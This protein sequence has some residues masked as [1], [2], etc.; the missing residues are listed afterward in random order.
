M[1][2]LSVIN[3]RA[4][5]CF[6]FVILSLGLFSCHRATLQNTLDEI[7]YRLPAPVE[8][9]VMAN[10]I[11]IVDNY[12]VFHHS[13]DETLCDLMSFRSLSPEV[14]LKHLRDK[15]VE[16]RDF[17]RLIRRCGL[18]LRYEYVGQGSGIVI[19]CSIEN[20]QL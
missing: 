15:G 9:G 1:S 20:Q 14:L 2:R 13:V 5:L 8:K 3:L 12:V 11:E 10:K 6:L 18:G 4:A 17:L 19:A 7:N 16:E